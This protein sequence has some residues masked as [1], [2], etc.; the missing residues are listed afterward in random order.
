[1]NALVESRLLSPVSEAVDVLRASGGA[2]AKILADVTV[3]LDDYDA[4]LVWILATAIQDLAGT[5]QRLLRLK[6]EKK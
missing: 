2:I 6:E 4:D 5:E 3:V 1:M